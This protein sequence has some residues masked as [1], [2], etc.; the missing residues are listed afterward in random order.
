MQSEN[1]FSNFAEAM[2][3]FEAKPQRARF[4]ISMAKVEFDYSTVEFFKKNFFQSNTNHDKMPIDTGVSA[5]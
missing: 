1:S 5:K 4:L 2:V 3:L